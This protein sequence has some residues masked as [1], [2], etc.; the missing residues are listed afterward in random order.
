MQHRS[1]H[2]DKK[3][4]KHWRITSI[5]LSLLGFLLSSYTVLHHNTVKTLGKSD[6]FCN[7]SE[8][9][10]CDKVAQSN[11]SELLGIPLGVYGASYFLAIFGLLALASWQGKFR[12]KSQAAYAILVW[13]GVLVSA[14]LAT[15]SLGQIHSLCLACI[16]VYLITVA[17][18]GLWLYVTGKSRPDFR[19]ALPGLAFTLAVVVLGV[20]S[21]HL[22][23]ASKDVAQGALT[24]PLHQEEVLASSQRD[25]PIATTPYMGKGEDYRLG[26][27]SAPVRIVKFSDFQCP[28]CK[29]MATFLHSLQ[30]DFPEQVQII[31][32][33][34]PLDPSCN[35]MMKRPM[36]PFACKIA[37]LARCAGQIGK[38]W[39]YAQEAFDD[40]EHADAK[41]AENWAT[42]VGLSD[43]DIKRCLSDKSIV[44]KIQNDVELGRKLEIS[45]T[46][47]IF[48]NGRAFIGS[49]NE[50]LREEVTKILSQNS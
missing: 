5:A 2:F 41:K 17:Q 13:V 12:E 18:L 10:N 26:P 19:Q 44:E 33:N 16:G 30:K 50:K 46:P 8:L 23:F 1:P 42:S 43:A 6:M 40:Q 31:Y 7:L 14:I 27:D 35:S 34:F 32:Y 3:H 28:A 9:F 49:S 29:H 15:I 21:S 37:I 24:N 25:I 48:V 4:P 39:Q 22:L 38:F 11:F 45:G 20:T 47:T 36:H